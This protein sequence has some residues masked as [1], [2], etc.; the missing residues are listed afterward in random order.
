MPK[1]YR[2]RFIPNETM[3]LKE[4]IILY[5]DENI[6]LTRWNAIRPKP[7]LSHGFSCYL[8]KEGLKISKFK[9]HQNELY[10]WYCDIVEISFCKEENSYLFT[11]L[12]ADVTISKEGSVQVLDLDELAVA[13]KNN[14]ITK[15]QLIKALNSTQKLLD[16]IETG[17]FC[18]YQNLIDQY[19]ENQ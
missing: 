1:L 19:D 2:K 15:E 16:W 6:L 8:L 5:L 17:Q 14:L 4:D 7:K 18:Q 11:D 3:E 10:L 13:V 12:L 9:D